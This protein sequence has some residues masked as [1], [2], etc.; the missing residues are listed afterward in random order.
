M[1]L[2]QCV[3][4][5]LPQMCRYETSICR[6]L[7]G[8]AASPIWSRSPIQLCPLGVSV[9]TALHDTLDDGPLLPKLSSFALATC[10]RTSTALDDRSKVSHGVYSAHICERQSQVMKQVSTRRRRIANFLT[11]AKELYQI[12]KAMT[13]EHHIVVTW[14]MLWDLST[15]TGR[16]P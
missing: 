8:E 4:A 12:G 9:A 11:Q 6:L 3:L 7:L 2:S 16:Y 5:N 15:L 13:S 10:K 1:L 14:S